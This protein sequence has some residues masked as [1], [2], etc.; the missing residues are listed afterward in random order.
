MKKNIILLFL[1]FT[2]FINAEH[3]KGYINVSEPKYSL[4]YEANGLYRSVDGMLKLVKE[5]KYKVVDSNLI[6]YLT[7]KNSK[8][9]G[10]FTIFD[11]KT[12]KKISEFNYKNG[13]KTGKWIDYN[14][15]G[16]I[17]MIEYYKNN[18]LI[19]RNTLENG[20]VIEKELI[21]EEV[22]NF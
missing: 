8:F 22:E 6:T 3:F 2:L 17:V 16:E 11:K 1:L 14:D 12:N 18:K 9:H 20:K 5:G 15:S 4:I 19:Q 21:R 10:K 13:L 7:I